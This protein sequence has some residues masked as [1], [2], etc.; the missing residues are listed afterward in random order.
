[1]INHTSGPWRVA[2]NARVVVAGSPSAI[3]ATIAGTESERLGNARAIHAVPE[4]IS[5]VRVLLTAGYPGTP[6]HDAALEV[7]RAALAKAGL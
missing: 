3:V 4:L 2:Y 5:A 7:G 6:T 1:M